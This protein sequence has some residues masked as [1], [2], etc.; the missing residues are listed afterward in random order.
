MESTAV[1]GMIFGSVYIW[2]RRYLQES[3]GE[4][5]A[6]QTPESGAG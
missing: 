5:S 2:M 1:C 6:K 4:F 3:A